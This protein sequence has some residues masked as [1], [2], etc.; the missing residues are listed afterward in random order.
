ME[1]V[2]KLLDY[3]GKRNSWMGHSLKE[4]QAAFV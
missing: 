3:C 1:N 4:S 2:F